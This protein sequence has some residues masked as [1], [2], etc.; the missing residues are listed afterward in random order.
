MPSNLVDVLCYQHDS[1]TR[2]YTDRLLDHFSCF[3]TS[4]ATICAALL[5]IFV[6]VAGNVAVVVMSRIMLLPYR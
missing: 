2:F 6:V 3:V 4:T 5:L 1:K